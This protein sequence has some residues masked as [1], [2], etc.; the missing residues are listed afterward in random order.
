[1]LAAPRRRAPTGTRSSS[2]ALKVAVYNE[3]APFSD[4]GAGIDVDLAQALARGWA[5]AEP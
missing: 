3:F 4:K 1:M 2:R 5:E